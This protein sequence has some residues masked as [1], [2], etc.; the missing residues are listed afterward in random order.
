M[1]CPTNPFVTFG[2]P[3]FAQVIPIGQ[4]PNRNVAGTQMLNRRNTD[5]I[6]DGTST[7]RRPQL[8]QIIDGTFAETWKEHRKNVSNR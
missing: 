4:K 2:G 1:F 6:K 8:R 5:G 3:E 7:K